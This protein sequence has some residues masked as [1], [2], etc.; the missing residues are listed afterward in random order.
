MNHLKKS[1]CRNCGEEIIWWEDKNKWIHDFSGS[2]VCEG[3][4]GH[5]EP[6]VENEQS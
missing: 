3:R 6:E 2:I 5:A 4:K 1:I